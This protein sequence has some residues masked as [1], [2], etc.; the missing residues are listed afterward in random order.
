[1][2]A[3]AAIL[4]VLAIL[5]ATG[6]G[7]WSSETSSGSL[8]DLFSCTECKLG[9]RKLSSF[10]E[11]GKHGS[12]INKGKGYQGREPVPITGDEC[13]KSSMQDGQQDL[14]ECP[15]ARFLEQRN[16]WRRMKGGEIR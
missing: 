10:V 1:M 15:L 2:R 11:L 6:D 13:S 3:H 9:H 14:T 12:D 8:T 7:V 5:L 16:A 4:V